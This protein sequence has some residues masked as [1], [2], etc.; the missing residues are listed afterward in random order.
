MSSVRISV[1]PKLYKKKSLFWI[2]MWR[3]VTNLKKTEDGHPRSNRGSSLVSDSGNISKYIRHSC[4]CVGST[5]YPSKVYHLT[6][7]CMSDKT[8]HLYILS[9][10]KPNMKWVHLID[11]IVR[12]KPN[13]F[14]IISN[15]RK[16]SEIKNI[17]N[18]K[19]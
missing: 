17:W 4:I 15:Y 9:H 7:R 11:C 19:Y 14:F 6:T 12:K 18:S 10:S 3:S 8:L 2:C 5:K 13:I 16:H 1:I